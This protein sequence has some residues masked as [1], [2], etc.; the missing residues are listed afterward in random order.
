M[1]SKISIL[2]VDDDAGHR[3]MLTT[4]LADDCKTRYSES[5][6]AGKLTAEERKARGIFR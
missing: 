1:K 5:A 4:L 2:V 3:H 6:A